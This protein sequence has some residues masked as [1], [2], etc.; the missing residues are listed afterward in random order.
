MDKS[1]RNKMACLLGRFFTSILISG[2]SNLFPVPERLSLGIYQ[3]F[4]YWKKI[5]TSRHQNWC[6]KSTQKASHF[7]HS[8]K[9]QV[10]QKINIWGAFCSKRTIELQFF[11]GNMDSQKCIKILKNSRREMNE[12]LH[13][14]WILQW[15]NDS[16]HFSNMTLDYYI[17]NDVELL[18][19][20]PYSPGLN[21][22]ENIWGAI[23]NKLAGRSFK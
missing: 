16:K 11:E 3:I 13:D 20:P 5:W 18:K 23:K 10:R 22:I 4:R 14:K 17:E 7:I 19:W 2:S 1:W 15:D 9:D 21:P 12:L 6:E 8:N